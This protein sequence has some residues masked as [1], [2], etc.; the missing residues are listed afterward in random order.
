[1][2]HK[3]FGPDRFSRF[4]VYWIQTD[5]QTPSQTNQKT[6][7]PQTNRKTN[8]HRGAL[9]FNLF[10]LILIYI[11]NFNIFFKSINFLFKYYSFQRFLLWRIEQMK[12]IFLK[13]LRKLQIDNLRCYGNIEYRD[14]GLKIKDNFKDKDFIHIKIWN[15]I[16]FMNYNNFRNFVRE[17]PFFY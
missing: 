5:T 2:S 3:K 15:S 7:N 12:K 8:M 16:F 4:D 14:Q 17:L 9:L 11:N 13:I 10:I 1:M 6:D